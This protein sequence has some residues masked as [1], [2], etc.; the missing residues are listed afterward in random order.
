MQWRLCHMFSLSFL[1]IG[2]GS[3]YL[4]GLSPAQPIRQQRDPTAGDVVAHGQGLF[5]EQPPNLTV[6][7]RNTIAHTVALVD[8]LGELASQV[9]VPVSSGTDDKLTMQHEVQLGGVLKVNKRN[10][11]E[12]R[13]L[14]NSIIEV[15]WTDRPKPLKEPSPLVVENWQLASPALH[16][17]D[18]YTFLQKVHEAGIVIDMWDTQGEGIVTVTIRAAQSRIDPQTS[19]TLLGVALLTNEEAHQ[20]QLTDQEWL[21]PTAMPSPGQGPHVMVQKPQVL[22]A[23]ETPTLTA[24]SPTDLLVVF[25]PNRAPVNMDSLEVQARKGIFKI[26]L[27]DRLKPYIQGTTIQ[28]P[29]LEI[30]S[31]KFLIEIGI[32]DVQGERTFRKYYLQVNK[33]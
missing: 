27:T 30:P 18:T 23:S 5:P 22:A 7:E 21:L 2:L 26:S 6:A 8:A 1:L 24:T 16:D 17:L 19:P 10:I 4:A 9:T 29:N 31:G 3:L 32:A 13:R 14:V 25:K 33:E 12:N 15:S 28:A 20:F 11:V